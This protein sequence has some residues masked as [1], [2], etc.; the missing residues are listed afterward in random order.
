MNDITPQTSRLPLTLVLSI[1]LPFAAGYFLSY[2]Y[3]TINSV[4]A[5]EIVH[6]V[7]VNAS[8]LG[9]LTSTFFLAFAIAQLPLGILLDRFGPRR[10]EAL[11]LL[12]AATGVALFGAGRDLPSLALGRALIGLGASACMMAAFKAFVQWFD[13]K[14]LPLVNGCLLGFGATGALA[15]TV[16]VQWALGFASW[17]MIFWG[18]A[19]I[20]VV[21]AI[22][23]W[24]VVPD[25]A[26]PPAHTDMA[27]QLRGIRTI[28]SDRFFWRVT[29]LAAVSQGCFLGIQGLWAG[30]WLQD[31]AH[32]SPAAVAAHLG[33]LAIAIIIGFFVTGS[34]AE[35]LMRRGVAQTTIIGAGTALF[36]VVL[37]SLALGLTR[38]PLV[39]WIAFGFLGS[40][41]ML[42][43]SALSAAFPREL[44][45]RVNTALNLVAF[46]AA[47]VIQ[48][49]MGAIINLW[50]LPGTQSYGP[51]GYQAAFAVITAVQLLTLLWFLRPQRH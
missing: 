49:G 40:A 43:Y 4:L 8:E 1:F 38:A 46:V 37:L 16:P 14:R 25:H 17:R 44:A 29:P 48:W 28:F 27:S 19:A 20:T 32:L 24:L 15:A 13:V 36:T 22:S 7:G 5:P 50:R 30:P 47:F 26:E 45:G 42:A 39:T 41:S 33:A 18:I 51:A 6:A 21:V 3:R 31:A 9:L 10:V 2:V 23:L 12:L 35:R 34:V 11:L